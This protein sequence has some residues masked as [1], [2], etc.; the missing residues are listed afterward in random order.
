MILYERDLA[1][2][3][4][5]I[6]G[7][8]EKYCC[9]FCVD[10]GF[11]MYVNRHKQAW[12]CFKCG[13]GGKLKK[14]KFLWKEYYVTVRFNDDPIISVPVASSKEVRTLPRMIPVMQTDPFP[15][16]APINYLVSRG[17][18][19]NEIRN[20]NLGWCPDREGP[21]ANSIVFPIGPLDKPDYF[22]CRKLEGKPKY[23][24][25][26]WP[27]GKTV[28][29]TSGPEPKAIAIVEG[30]LDTIKTARIITTYGLLG[31]QANKE[32]LQFMVKDN[33]PGKFLIILDPDAWEASIRLKLGLLEM[34]DQLGKKIQVVNVF[35]NEKDP[36]DME[37]EELRKVVHGAVRR[38][39]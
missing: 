32:Q 30:P 14:P 10:T 5:F 35:L 2:K 4:S 20:N 39:K 29:I 23:V 17:L 37:T 34:A 16:N 31:K 28:Y 9:L 3:K 21:Y 1:N 18:S 13:Q 33:T 38:F 15:F 27:K 11:H 36:G 24:N 19:G 26:P 25:A 6:S 22:V 8:E 7:D 12:H